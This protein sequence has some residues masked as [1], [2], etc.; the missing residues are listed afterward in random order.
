MWLRHL[1]LSLSPGRLSILRL[2]PANPDLFYF[3]ICGFKDFKTKAF[4]FDDLA[5]LRNASG[6]GADEPT[7]GGGIALVKAHVKEVLQA[8]DVNGALHDISVVAFTDDV[9]RKL[10]L[11]A[12]FA[13]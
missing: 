4:I 3:A 5:R 9:M 2:R 6:D 10:V 7:D 13:D 11:V 8:A 1:C 12:N